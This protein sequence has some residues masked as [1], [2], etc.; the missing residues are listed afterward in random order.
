MNG[1]DSEKMKF[2]VFEQGNTTRGSRNGLQKRML[3]HCLT[4]RLRNRIP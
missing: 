4:I 1:K 3:W 2:L